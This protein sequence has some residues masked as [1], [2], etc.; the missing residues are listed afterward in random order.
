MAES[1]WLA[2][3]FEEHRSHLRAVAYR[4][5]GSMSEADDAVQDAW[6]RFSQADTS[7]VEN[8]GGWLTTI[9]ARVCLNLLRTR[10]QRGEQSLEGR[11]PE[12]IISPADS[13][14][15]QQEALLSDAV[16]L[17]M[18]VVLD[19]LAL[20]ER[21]AF[22]LHDVF[23]VP[24]D[25]IG[26][27]VGRTPPAARQLASRARRRV[28]GTTS[29]PDADLRQQRVV[30]DAF[31]AASRSGDFD[32]LLALLDP[33]VVARADIGVLAPR[34]PRTVRGAEAVAAQAIGFRKLAQYARPAMVNGTAGLVVIRD[35]Q[36][37]A[38]LGFSIAGGRIVELDIF[39]DPALLGDLDLAALAP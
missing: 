17:A 34:A 10:R 25:E 5:L 31:Q 6:L 28:R 37:F 30:V 18:L 33:R 39:S 16:G 29:M 26:P 2:E 24:F 27:V 4:M 19:R 14:D 9:V 11:L 23:G 35:G 20:A 3:R 8:L 21:V 32:A 1:D 13:P 36:P 22:V 38:V 15:P 12:P 7:R